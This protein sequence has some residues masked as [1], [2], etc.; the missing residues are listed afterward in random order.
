LAAR[1]GYPEDRRDVEHNHLSEALTHRTFA[2]EFSQSKRGREAASPMRDNQRLE[3]LG[4]AVLGMIIASELMTHQPQASEG[5]LSASRARL[6][7]A[8]VLADIAIELGLETYLR[9]GRGES[10]MGE[11]A[12][13]ARLAD[14]TEAVIGALYLDLGLLSAHAWVWDTISPKYQ[15]LM[16]N[17]SATF[18]PKT[19][20]QH[21]AHQTHQK[22]PTYRHQ[23]TN[24][25]SSG[26]QVYTAQVLLDDEVIGYG[27]GSNKKFAHFAAAQ[28]ALNKS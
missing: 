16:H 26:E 17:N 23:V 18:D 20:L 12:R 21:W 8:D 3:F 2:H 6:I 28:N 19:A 24:D 15:K 5:V 7:N 1:L 4:D 10:K 13:R 14:L 11:I 27:K 9:I 22:T 25:P